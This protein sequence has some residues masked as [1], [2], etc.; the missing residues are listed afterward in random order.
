MLWRRNI[1][2]IFL[3]RVS[4][5]LG[6]HEEKRKMRGRNDVSFILETVAV[7]QLTYYTI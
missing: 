3:L 5:M 1:G 6:R 7:S 4:A 2:L